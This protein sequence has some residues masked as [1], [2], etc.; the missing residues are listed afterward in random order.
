MIGLPGETDADVDECADFVSELS[1]IIPVALGVAP[2][3]AKRKTP[4]DGTPFAGV[5]VV[6]DRLA[7]L[8]SG[9]KGR[10]DVRSTSARWA[11]VEYALA[12][13]NEEEGLAVRN[14]VHAGGRFA[15]Y[16][17]ELAR[18]GYEP[19]EPTGP[20]VRSSMAGIFATVKKRES[21]GMAE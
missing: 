1:R 6:G 7:R 3:C 14:A 17:N 4:L 10:A 12:Q 5:G 2:F 9:L 19:T 18:L 15:D 20:R 21:V 16:R 13:G 11:W 8:R